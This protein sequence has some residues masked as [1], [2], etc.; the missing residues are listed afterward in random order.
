MTLIK[1]R[2]EA[3]EMNREAKI[4]TAET[5]TACPPGKGINCSGTAD[6]LTHIVINK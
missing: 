2:Q 1:F 3:K 6:S 5:G 4:R